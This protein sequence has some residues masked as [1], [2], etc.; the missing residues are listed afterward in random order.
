MLNLNH[1]AYLS[2]M[3]G[4]DISANGPCLGASAGKSEY[5]SLVKVRKLNRIPNDDIATQ[6]RIELRQCYRREKFRRRE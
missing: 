2:V 4:R 1:F 5:E 3:R 6:S